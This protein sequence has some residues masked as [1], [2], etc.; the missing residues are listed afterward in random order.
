MKR[1]FKLLVLGF[2]VVL[3]LA[4]GAGFWSARTPP[5]W[6]KPV[7]PS[8]AVKER[9]WTVERRLAEEFSKIRNEEPVWA[10]RVTE[11][12]L[13]A[14]LADRLRPWVEHRGAW[15]EAIGA[16][17][18]RLADGKVSLAVE[19][20]DLGSVAVLEAEPVASPE[21]GS[22]TLRWTSAGFGRLRLPWPD[23]GVRSAVLDRLLAGE[24]GSAELSALL[25]GL[26][27]PGAFDLPDGRRVSLLD[28]QIGDGEAVVGFVTAPRE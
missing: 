17:Q 15:P 26:S 22:V 13:N 12:D 14:W 3:A 21:D 4:I 6:F 18:V 20:V 1:L 11:A 23:A 9:G 8:E 27:L 19:L 5:T 10:V 28:A 24:A 7:P 2:F 25:D 16:T